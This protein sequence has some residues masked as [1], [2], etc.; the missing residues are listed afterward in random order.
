METLKQIY[1]SIGD[2][3]IAKVIASPVLVE[4]R[5]DGDFVEA[6]AGFD[7]LYFQQLRAKGLRNKY[8][9]KD[10]GARTILHMIWNPQDDSLYPN[11]GLEARGPDGEWIPLKANLYVPLP[12]GASIRVTVDAG[13]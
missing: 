5:N 4:I 6:I 9:V 8:L 7:I 12:Q 13:C 1:V 10:R 11:I 2:P 3:T